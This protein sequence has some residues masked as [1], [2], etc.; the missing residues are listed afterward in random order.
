MRKQHSNLF[1]MITA[2]IVAV[3]C[4]VLVMIN[5][6][7][8]EKHDF[9]GPYTGKYL[10]RIAF[11]I[12]G[13]GAG[14]FCLTGTGSI[15]HLSVDNRPDIFNEP[16][17]FAAIS[18]K[19]LDNGAKILQRLEPN[20]KCFGRK[21]TGKGYAAGAYGLPHFT[22][23]Q[24]I[25]RF[26]FATV[27]L[28]DSDIPM[29]VK[30]TGWSPF[31][32]G[33]VDNSSLPAGALEYKFTNTSSKVME[34]VFSYSSR[35]IIKQKGKN[36]I[37]KAK[38]GYKMVQFQ[39]EDETKPH[40]EFTISV[41]DDNA[42]VDYC[43]FRGGW[44]DPLTILWK[45]ISECN[46]VSNEP[47]E[48]GAPGATIYLPV[49][50]QP[51]EEKT[52]TVN[53][54]WYTP[55]S[56]L[57]T[58]HTSKI[59]EE[60]CFEGNCF[61]YYRPWYG[62]KFKNVEEVTKYWKQ[63]YDKN[64]EMSEKFRDAFY[65]STLPPVVLEAV[66][67][68]LTILK[69]PTVLRTYNG[70]MWAWEG[71]GDEKGSCAGSCTHVW[72]YAQAICH[73]FPSMERTL[74]ETEFK[75]SQNELGHQTFRDALPLAIP[76]HKF[77]AATDGQL[78]GIMK[79]Y[80][81]WRISGDT[82]WMK[83]LYPLVKKSMD[84]CIKT[85]DPRHS[86]V[87]EEPHH[88]TYDIE[89]WGPD[90]MCT[91]FY[92]G[93]LTSIIELSKAAGEPYKEYA[94]LLDK[95]KNYMEKE[96]FNDEYYIQ[97]I[98]IEG[99]N[100]KDPVK[101]IE[102]SIYGGYSPEAIE[103]LKKEGPKYQYG[104]GCLSDG[105]LGMWIAKVCGL[106]EVLDNDQVTSHL[107]SIHKYNLFDDL[108]DHSNPQRPTFALGTEGGLLLCTWPKGGTLSLPF[109]Y[110]NEVWTGIE[111]QVASHLMFKGEVEKGLDIVRECRKRY[112]GTIRN[113]FNE[114][115][116]GHWYARA[117]ASYGLFEGLTGVRYDAVDKTLYINSQIGDDFTTFLSTAT[118]FGNVS[119]K[120][121]KPE[122]NVEYGEIDVKN[123][124]VSGE[125]V[126]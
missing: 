33:D 115:E 54:C 25:A 18:I 85:W 50:L 45:N 110:S 57:R 63:H 118:G 42:V 40:S 102:G 72:N 14:M 6:N 30:I 113:P 120:N 17:A 16:F 51:G 97:K 79:V 5:T 23:G 81:E 84:Y 47:V 27:D 43:W 1:L 28:Q 114:I 11:P 38:N 91:S 55:E 106:D 49:K 98:Q 2:I 104:T 86:G 62:S 93:A 101:A 31:I 119:L 4:T 36:A 20:W 15:S 112:D 69:S 44:F 82:E 89:F 83:E 9:N 46:I 109:V 37:V 26:P 94:S 21:R 22:D 99:L 3:L 7:R 95:G 124:F 71:C 56:G 53:F 105:I 60:P 8:P 32:P 64:K 121:G 88:N 92:L 90:G 13:M 39:Q 10:D 100:A 108:S 48:T 35:N 73:L 59:G 107:V 125:K 12:G 67:A 116:C 76:S 103:L 34:A 65:N 58:G 68:N 78:G 74:R 80:R 61:P 77:H 126:K 29:D 75:I 24:F 87:L 117:M 70:K 96:L 111:Y 41:N 52:V 123:I 19:G 122:V 66:A